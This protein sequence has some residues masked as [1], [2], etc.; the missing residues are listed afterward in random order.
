MKFRKPQHLKED[1]VVA[2]LT[3]IAIAVVMSL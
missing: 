2:L 3:V 1:L